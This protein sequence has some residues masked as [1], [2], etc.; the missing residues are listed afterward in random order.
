MYLQTVLMYKT[1]TMCAYPQA[2][3]IN[4]PKRQTF[5]KRFIIVSSP[6][7]FLEDISKLLIKLFYNVSKTNCDTNLDQIRNLL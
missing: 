5:T 2:I 7:N 4:S 1:S 3:I 6:Y